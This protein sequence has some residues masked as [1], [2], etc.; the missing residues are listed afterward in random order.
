MAQQRSI[1]LRVGIFVLLCLVVI[2][3]LIIKFGK[4]ERFSAKTYDI[5]V[6]F[7]NV[8][9]IVRD[10]NVMYAGIPVGKVREIRL[11]ENGSLKV[12]V[13]LAIYEGYQ[14]RKDAK[15][16]INQ[17]GLLGDRYIDVIPQ[18]ATAPPIK[19]GETVE[20]SS[21]VDLTEAIRGVVDVLHQA[22]GTIARIDDVVRRTDEAVKRIDDFVLSTQSLTHISSTFANID[23]TTSNA[24]AFT[25]SLR[26]VVDDSRST[27][28]NTMTQLSLAADNIGMASKRVED[29]VAGNQDKINDAVRNAK[30]STQ[31]LNDILEKLQHGEGTAGK[32]IVDPTL[33]DELVKLV[34]NWREYGILYKEG[35][36]RD[37]KK[38]ERENFGP[39][40]T[41]ARPAKTGADGLIFGTD[42]TK[43][44]N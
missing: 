10:A 30:E 19:P 35:P 18:G 38:I 2:G 31:R 44:A 24:V 25:V 1:E 37:R 11:T 28:S 41:P 5:T 8:G 12:K 29:L 34:R 27:L 7:P 16:V 40:P 6:V 14:I 39:A 17:S 20:G 9:G 36:S 15:F 21:S 23:E 3:G 22:A 43:P 4:L 32:L 33:H 13:T 42:E 26:A